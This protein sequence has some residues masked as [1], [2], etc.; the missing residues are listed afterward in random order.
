MNRSVKSKKRN[1]NTRNVRNSRGLKGSEKSNVGRLFSVITGPFSAFFKQWFLLPVF[2][3][4]AILVVFT[5]WLF[6]IFMPLSDTPPPQR[7]TAIDPIIV[8]IRASALANVK[9]EYYEESVTYQKPTSYGS[10]IPDVIEREQGNYRYDH[11]FEEEV[12]E[13]EQ[14]VD[15]DTSTDRYDE[16]YQEV[17]R[18]ES[19]YTNDETVSALT[20][21]QESSHDDDASETWLEHKVQ[22]GEN[23]TRIFEEHG[24]NLGDLYAILAIEGH[25][26]PIS[27]IKVGQA[28]RF[29]VAPDH[30]IDLLEIDGESNNPVAF[31]R[32][33]SGKFS[34]ID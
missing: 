7:K 28:L 4:R 34:R 23:F 30:T 1:L 31:L 20:R 12:V 25:G 5:L 24:L 2:H 33:H 3:Q 22:R 21:E 6:V 16:P 15:A 13:V 14:D 11:D 17:D 19:V 9:E 32:Q 8:P 29:R 26:K 27:R 18:E 10:P